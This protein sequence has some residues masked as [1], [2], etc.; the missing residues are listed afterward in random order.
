LKTVLEIDVQLVLFLR[1]QSGTQSILYTGGGFPSAWFLWK[2]TQQNGIDTGCRNGV[3]QLAPNGG[4]SLYQRA[5]A[6]YSDQ[7]RLTS[8]SMFSVTDLI[9]ARDSLFYA[10]FSTGV[11]NF[12][13]IGYP[14]HVMQ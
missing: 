9:T 11:T 8:W 10:T 2:S 13:S 4:I 1:V 3:L 14:V 5:G 6:A 7:N 12:A